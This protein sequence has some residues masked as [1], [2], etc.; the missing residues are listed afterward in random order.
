MWWQHFLFITQ[1]CMSSFFSLAICT[2]F[3]FPSLSI[4]GRAFYAYLIKAPVSLESF[5]NIKFYS[6]FV[7]VAAVQSLSMTI[8]FFA[9]GGHGGILLFY[10]GCSTAFAYGIVSVAIG[11]GAKY[12]RFDWEHLSQLAVGYGNIIFMLT[13]AFWVLVHFYPVWMLI[14][15]QGEVFRAERFLILIGIILLDLLAHKLLMRQGLKGLAAHCD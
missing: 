10:I 14:S 3:V 6:W 12:S 11:L 13:G 9:S 15:M 4:E 7:V 1:F 8:G 5:I 2:R